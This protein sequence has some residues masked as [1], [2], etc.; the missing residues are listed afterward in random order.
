VT[1]TIEDIDGNPIEGQ[2]VT[3]SFLSG[4]IS[5]DTILDTSTTTNANG[6]AT[7]QMRFAC[8]PHSVT[9]QA[10]ADAA[11]GTGVLGITGEGLP[12]TDTATES[13]FPAMALAALAV[14]I[15]SATILR[16]FAT[17]RR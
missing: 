5:G 12:R 1:A 9:F 7:T 6:V 11:T 17:D 8:S 14:L 2:P 16:R 13:S 15:G 3:W 10:Q 4:N